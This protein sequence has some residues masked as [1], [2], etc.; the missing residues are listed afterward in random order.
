MGYHSLCCSMSSLISA[1][2]KRRAR[3]RPRAANAP[4]AAP[5]SP[6]TARAGRPARRGRRAVVAAFLLQRAVDALD[7][8]G[9]ARDAVVDLDQAGHPPRRVTR[10]EVRLEAARVLGGPARE[11]P[12]RHVLALVVEQSLDRIAL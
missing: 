12:V 9:L 6:P 1:K 11:P 8:L 10:L 3:S 2:S 4:R 7:A 5:P